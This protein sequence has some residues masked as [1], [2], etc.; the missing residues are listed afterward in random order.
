MP[1]DPPRVLAAVPE[2]AKESGDYAQKWSHVKYR[3]LIRSAENF[4]VFI[5][6]DLDIDWITSPEYDA[7]GHKDNE[8][9]NSILNDAASLEATPCDGLRADMRLL[10][11]RLIGEGITR[12]LEHDYV[13][14]AK[15]LEEAGAYVEARSKETSRF[16]YLSGSFGLVVPLAVTGIALWLVR[17]V[18]LEAFGFTAFWLALSVVAGALGA[19]MSV[20]ER[21]GKLQFDCSAGRA[22]HYMEAASR[23]SIGALSGFVAALGVRAELILGPLARGEKLPAIMMIAAIAAGT[24]ERLATSIIST[25]GA[26]HATAASDRGRRTKE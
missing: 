12:S 24:G 15:M 14:A 19:V 26:S 23:I 25:I 18:A 16:W 6:D 2:T 13:S 22:L 3:Y 7:K 9:H 4:I 1:Q 5:D 17:K 10:F 8:R 20:I 21:S 11:K